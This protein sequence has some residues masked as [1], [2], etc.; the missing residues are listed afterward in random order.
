MF[1]YFL[2]YFLN[3]NLVGNGSQ[4]R[5]DRRTGINLINNFWDIKNQKSLAVSNIAIKHFLLLKCASLFELKCVW[6]LVMKLNKGYCRIS[7]TGC[8]KKVDNGSIQ[9]CS[10]W[11]C[12]TVRDKKGKCRTFL[13]KFE[14]FIQHHKNSR[15]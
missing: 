13:G 14:H 11:N 10:R 5:S 12:R 9:N 1:V 2:Y 7:E 6:T 4:Y 8:S 3:I 15:I